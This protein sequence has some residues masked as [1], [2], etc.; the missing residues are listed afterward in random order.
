MAI[1]PGFR[2]VRP[3]AR[4]RLLCL[5]YAGAGAAIYRKWPEQFAESIDVC[6]IELPGR[7]M[8]MREPLIDD[9]AALRDRILD[10]VAPLLDRPI[11][12]FGHSLGAKLAFEISKALGPRVVH[13]FASAASA[14]DAPLVGPTAHLPRNELVLRLRRLG[15]VPD[16]VLEDQEVLDMLLPIVRADLRIIER[17]RVTDGV[18]APGGV[19]VFAG[20]ADDYATLD[21]T[22]GWEAFSGGA[23]RFVTFDG[24]HFYMADATAALAAEITRDLE[25]AGALSA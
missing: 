2:Q 13:L 18:R 6:P 16:K 24:G 15:G 10:D 1:V 3:N 8:R 4:V 22:R 12:L 11:A 20:K 7:G 17:Y 23:F 25:K 21:K 14:P 9:M 19:T 5:P